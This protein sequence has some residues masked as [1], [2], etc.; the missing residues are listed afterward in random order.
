VTANPAG[1][2]TTQQAR[3]LMM[4]LEGSRLKHAAELLGEPVRFER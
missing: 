4:D 2:W 3:D 1:P